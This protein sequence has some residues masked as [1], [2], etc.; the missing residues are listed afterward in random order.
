MP[1]RERATAGACWALLIVLCI[2]LIGTL[3]EILASQVK[4]VDTYESTA[5]AVALRWLRLLAAGGLSG[6]LA[7]VWVV[8][9]RSRLRA[10]LAGIPA[11][12]PFSAAMLVWPPQ[13]GTAWLGMLALQSSVSGIGVGLVTWSGLQARLRSAAPPNESAAGDAGPAML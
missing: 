10:A 2:L 6:A 5:P 7:G 4:P 11:M 3:G 8:P 1:F 12:I 13:G 9:T